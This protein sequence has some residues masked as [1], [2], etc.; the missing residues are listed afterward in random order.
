MF[1]RIFLLN[2]FETICYEECYTFEIGI[3]DQVLMLMTDFVE[4]RS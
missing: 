3:V 4:F 2:C 1:S